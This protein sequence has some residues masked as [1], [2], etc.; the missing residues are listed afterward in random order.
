MELPSPATLAVAG[1]LV[2]V[3]PNQEGLLICADRRTYDSERGDVD[4]NL[5]I[6]KLNKWAA[7]ASTGHTTYRR[8]SDFS[9]EYDANVEAGK[10][11]A[12]NGF[13]PSA[14]YWNS[15][16]AQI[17][18]DFTRYAGKHPGWKPQNPSDHI[19]FQ[20]IFSYFDH[21]QKPHVVRI[22]FYFDGTMR[23]NDCT[24]LPLTSFLTFGNTAVPLELLHGKDPRFEDLRS[25]LRMK[26]FL[27]GPVRADSVTPDDAKSFALWLIR[28]TSEMTHLLENST[29][30]VGPTAD[31]AMV[32][33]TR[34][35]YWFPVD[36]GKHPPQ[37]K[38]PR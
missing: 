21:A 32:S 35:F 20:T 31:C 1:T 8:R 23:G 38:E 18:A 25:Q 6:G 34:G 27:T 9:V 19:L 16:E 15:L 26:P 4:T 29:D 17:E 11:V 37:P 3:V 2:V 24:E 33:R 7:V 14:A 30:H 28:V 36:A 10:F 22:R 13:S 5:K 12:A